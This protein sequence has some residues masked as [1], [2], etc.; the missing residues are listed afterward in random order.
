MV[1]LSVW[2]ELFY[3]LFSSWIKSGVF[4]P[5]HEGLLPDYSHPLYPLPDLPGCQSLF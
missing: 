4:S 3:L 5:G 2:A 1:K